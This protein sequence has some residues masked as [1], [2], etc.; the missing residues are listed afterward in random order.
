MQKKKLLQG[1][2]MQVGEKNTES[3]KKGNEMGTRQSKDR[4]LCITYTGINQELPKSSE[5][6]SN[7]STGWRFVHSSPFFDLPFQHLVPLAYPSRFIFQL[8]VQGRRRL[9]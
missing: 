6:L 3:D 5:L 8:L 9:Y 1:Q 7:F 4:Q 2:N